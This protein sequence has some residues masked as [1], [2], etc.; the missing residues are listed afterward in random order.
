M[1]VV[2]GTRWLTIEDEDGV[3][4]LFDPE[5]LVRLEILAA[6]DNKMENLAAA[7]QARA[8]AAQEGSP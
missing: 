8:T 4:R 2:I 1:L 5:D 6:L 7:A 3:R